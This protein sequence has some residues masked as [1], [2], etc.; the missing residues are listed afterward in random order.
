MYR[1]AKVPF[2]ILTDLLIVL[3]SLILAALIKYDTIFCPLLDIKNIS[4]FILLCGV[5]LLSNAL[6]GCYRCVWRLAGIAEAFRQCMAAFIEAG[7][8]FISLIVFEPV[9]YSA[10]ILVVLLQLTMMCAVRFSIRFSILIRSRIQSIIGRQNK[11]VVIFG[12]IRDSKAII[13][14]NYTENAAGIACIISSNSFKEKGFSISGVKIYGH[15]IEALEKYLLKHPTDEIILSKN[16]TQTDSLFRILKLCKE[17]KCQLKVYAGIENYSGLIRSINVEDLLERSPAVPDRKQIFD[18][19][20]GK[21]VLVTGGAGSIGS[22]IC[23]Q[24]LQND[25]HKLVI[26]DINENG[27]F[28]LD[29][30]LSRRFPREKYSVAVGSVRDAERLDEIFN[31]CRPEIVFHAAAHKHVPLME[32]NAGEAIKNNVFGT[33]NAA[34]KSIEYEAEKFILISSDKAVNPVNVMGATKRIAELIVQWLNKDSS[35]TRLSAV[36]FGNVLDSNGSVVQIFRK[37]IMEGGPVTITH[38]LMERY[39]MTIAEAVQLVLQAGFMA[40][41]GE[42]FMLNMGKPVKV[43]DLAYAMIRLYG[44]EPQKDIRIKYIGPRQGEKLFEEL[45][46][47]DEIKL[48]TENSGIFLCKPTG[49]DDDFGEKLNALNQSMSSSGNY[50][51]MLKSILKQYHPA[52]QDD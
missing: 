37:Q 43:V 41:G 19:V 52:K 16:S 46:F 36:R 32:T 14:K 31:A 6:L 34:R 24:V 21:N 20:H 1:M 51:E 47:K 26:V 45:F 15:G 30:E 49:P 9:P 10:A 28:L 2:L 33:Y 5:T 29:Q 22:E 38:P 42:V 23:R 39:F 3:L 40:D 50:K 25:C 7:L 48:V 12:D 8:F 35:S 18:L 4:F 44:F 27:L 17:Y 11:K 13:E